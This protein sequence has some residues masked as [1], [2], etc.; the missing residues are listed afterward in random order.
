MVRVKERKRRTRWMRWMKK[1]TRSILDHC[2]L[3]SFI[4]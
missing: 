1:R 4:W 2:P 3:L